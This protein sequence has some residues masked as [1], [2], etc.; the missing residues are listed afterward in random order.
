MAKYFS[1]TKTYR[2]RHAGADLRPPTSLG[3][4]QPYRPVPPSYNR[5]GPGGAYYRHSLDLGPGEYS[6]LNPAASEMQGY[7]RYSRWAK[8]Y[9]VLKGFGRLA[10]AAGVAL[11][12]YETYELLSGGEYFFKK[13]G[14]AGGPPPGYT[15]TSCGFTINPVTGYSGGRLCGALALTAP[16]YPVADGPQ[17]PSPQ[18]WVSQWGRS[19]PTQGRLEVRWFP[20][21]GQTADSSL[22]QPVPARNM[23]ALPDPATGAKSSSR[24][25][26]FPR[27]APPLS[28]EVEIGYQDWTPRPMRPGSTV[29]TEFHMGPPSS[30]KT[31]WPYRDGVPSPRTRERKWKLGKG[32]PIGDAFG[33]LTEFSDA[34]DCADKAIGKKHRK[35][36]L[37]K[38]SVWVANNFDVSD[39]HMVAQFIKCMALSNLSDIAIGKLSSA[40]G[41]AYGEATGAP[42]GPGIKRGPSLG[43]IKPTSDGG[44]WF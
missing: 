43:P 6:R 35:M 4:L 9:S 16:W 31:D 20:P 34:L 25:S 40:A 15:S 27:T 39:P 24:N 5:S 36:S 12:A 38:K 22:F 23:Q 32:G 26:P 21:T 10:G 18:N 37:P 11:T 7:Q 42:R 28:E 3:E 1:Q 29:A 17:F 13:S 30:G 44:S 8:N 41:K 19:S 14:S 2:F 33:A